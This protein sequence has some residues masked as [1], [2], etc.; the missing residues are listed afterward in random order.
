M[1]YYATLETLETQSHVLKGFLRA[2][3]RGWE[4]AYHEPEK[5]V[6][7]LIEEYPILRYEDEL[8]AVREI[9]G[10]VFTDKTREHG[11]GD[12]GTRHLGRADPHL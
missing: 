5:A 7:L 4:L 8:A 3:G 6:A 10:Y 1:P 11:L 12:D 2:T 9:L